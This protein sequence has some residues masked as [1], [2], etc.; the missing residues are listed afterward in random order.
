MLKLALSSGKFAWRTI[1]EMGFDPLMSPPLGGSA[2][3]MF[4]TQ[5]L[6]KMLVWTVIIVLV[7]GI[8]QKI[9][10]AAIRPRFSR[11]RHL[12]GPQVKLSNTSEGD[13]I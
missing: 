3:D 4:N 1:D 2:G 7:G 13:D 11:L 6:P 8:L 10:K 9:I 12:P 5:H